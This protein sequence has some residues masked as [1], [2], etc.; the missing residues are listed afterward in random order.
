MQIEKEDWLKSN[1]P[2]N[3]VKKKKISSVLVEEESLERYNYL[4]EKEKLPKIE[5]IQEINSGINE[6]INHLKIK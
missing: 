3:K 6:I 1:N 4:R 5:S 2:Y